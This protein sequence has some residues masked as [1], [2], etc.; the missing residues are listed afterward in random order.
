MTVLV[1]PI[2]THGEPE[3][4]GSP[5]PSR[6]EMCGTSAW[7]ERGEDG[8]L[9]ALSRDLA[10]EASSLENRRTIDCEPRQARRHRRAAVTYE[11]AGPL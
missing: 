4:S 7:L 3:G 5:P 8:T 9:E 1:M 10:V 6:R 11:N 2:P